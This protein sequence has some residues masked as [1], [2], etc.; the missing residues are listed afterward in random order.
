M[1]FEEGLSGYWPKFEDEIYQITSKSMNSSITCTSNF[2]VYN[3]R[4]N[5][6]GDWL[7]KSIRT[8]NSVGIDFHFDKTDGPPSARIY[9]DLFHQRE[10]DCILEDL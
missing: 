2:N 4:Y 1:E 3:E 8:K 6:I 5:L 10:I 7:E 9:A